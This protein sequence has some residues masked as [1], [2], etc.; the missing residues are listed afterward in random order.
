MFFYILS[1]QKGLVLEPGRASI[2]G[3]AL[4][5]PSARS[6]LP[7]DTPIRL[8]PPPARQLSSLTPLFC[9]GCK[10]ICAFPQAS[11]NKYIVFYIFGT[12]HLYIYIS[13]HIYKT[14]RIYITLVGCGYIYIYI[15]FGCIYIY[16]SLAYNL[17]GNIDSFVIYY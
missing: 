8:S 15:S 16:K 5:S 4:G 12:F 10:K 2:E 7:H 11:L 6:V 1:F 3:P 17:L 14:S 13:V 9:H